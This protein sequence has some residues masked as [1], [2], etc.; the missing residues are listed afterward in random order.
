[1]LKAS[2]HFIN[3]GKYKESLKHLKHFRAI[4][5]N[6]PKKIYFYLDQKAETEKPNE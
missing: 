5:P 2:E 6:L 1:M 4:I 3:N